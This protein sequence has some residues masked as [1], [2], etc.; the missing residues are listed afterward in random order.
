MAYEMH[1]V[2]PAVYRLNIHLPGMQNVTW[3]EDSAETMNEITE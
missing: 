3:N 1:Y 2:S